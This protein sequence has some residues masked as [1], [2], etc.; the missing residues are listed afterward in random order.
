MADTHYENP[1]IDRPDQS[2]DAADG[3]VSP[4][5]A[6]LAWVGSMLV[7][8][9]I[10]SFLTISKSAVFLFLASTGVTLCLGH[11]LGMHR[12]FIHRS[13][14]A[15]KWIEYLFVHFGVLVGLGGP[16]GMLRTHDI[17]DWAQRQLQCHSYFAHGEGWYRDLYWQLFCSIR[18][19]EPPEVEAEP[20]IADDPVYQFM[21][22]TWMLQQLPW[23][24][25]FYTIGG[26]SWVCW[27]IGSRVSVSIVG[28]WLIGYFAHNDGERD[29]H[30]E[31]AAV[32]GH[33]V[34]FVALLTMG[35]SWHNNHHAFPGS[36]RLGLESGQWDPGWWVLQLMER[37]GLAS[38]FVLPGDLPE[39]G[40]LRRVVQT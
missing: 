11:S 35:E 40:D 14:Q 29:W 2:A 1:R 24:L 5:P 20:A 27:G 7:L 4:D 26:W 31:G 23:A 36:A 32:Q 16:F 38:D 21:E 19:D 30:V 22:K 28:H 9:T 10:G 12:L 8:G 34:P 17:R 13:Y 18:L 15:P 25:L 39:R 3:T 6:K 37:L 33:N